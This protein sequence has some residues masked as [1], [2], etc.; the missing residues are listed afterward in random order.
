MSTVKQY[1]EF[2][3]AI[4]YLLEC[5]A[6]LIP[7]NGCY[8]INYDTRETAAYENAKKPKLS[9][10][11][12]PIDKQRSL[13]QTNYTYYN[14]WLG[15]IPASVELVCLDL[16]EGNPNELNQLLV[17]ESVDCCTIKTRRGWHYIMRPDPSWPKGN[18]NWQYKTCAGEV[19]YDNG[20]I[21]LWNPNKLVEF[22]KKPNQRPAGNSLAQAIKKKR[23]RSK[24][25]KAQAAKQKDLGFGPY[26]PGAR[27]ELLF[28]DLSQLVS[29]R[30]DDEATIDRIKTAWL[31]APDPK[32]Q[33]HYHRARIFDEK[34]ERLRAERTELGEF[35]FQHKDAEA[36]RQA[37]AKMSIAF[38]YN[39]RGNRFD[40]RIDGKDPSSNDDALDAWLIEELAKNFTYQR[41]NG[42]HPL[43]YSVAQF[44]QFMGALCYQTERRYD[45]FIRW[46]EN[47]P[48]W[49]NTPRL[50]G[51]LSKHFEAEHHELS[52]W[53]SRYPF[54]AAIQR[55]YQPGCQLDEIAVLIGK[56]GFGKT[57][58]LRSLFPSELAKEWYSSAFDFT[59]TS[60]ERV[61]ATMGAVIIEIGEM[62]GIGR[63]L[64]KQKVYLSQNTD[65]AR[66]AY[67]RKKSV[68]PRRF[69]FV[70]TADRK[71]VLPNDPSGNRRFVAI[72]L[73]KGCHIEKIMDEQRDQL[74][75]EALNDYQDNLRAN[76]PRELMAEQL[77]RNEEY[78]RSDDEFENQV[79][80]L[81][82]GKFYSLND[83]IELWDIRSPNNRIKNRISN[84]MQNGGFERTRQGRTKR[85]WIK[86]KKLI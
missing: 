84:A 17:E 41:G 82:E 62:A 64:Q 16:D 4:Q 80:E 40:W 11:R 72:E 2:A 60:R 81:D 85:G 21:M 19:R 39:L 79:A 5:D 59:A 33:G 15:L 53:A 47:L 67:D 44:N 51:F 24:K 43:R 49:D 38:R 54:I 73:H 10:R 32:N 29:K 46:L 37:L 3:D 70:G 50:S 20:Y 83:L 63:D 57:A 28:K 30:K 31:E 68:I 27:D 48:P 56:Q 6:H 58:F 14:N 18:W 23:S 45:P 77:S 35:H 1:T 25:A 74:W 22:L 65:H 42:Q 76:L 26:P 8:H 36:L 61:E 75:A 78:R 9:W 55:A 7:I 86:T 13:A 52:Y 12:T 71:E 69:A 66:L 34:L